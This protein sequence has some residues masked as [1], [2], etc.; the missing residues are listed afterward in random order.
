[1][2][3]CPLLLLQGKRTSV[4]TTPEAVIDENEPDPADQPAASGPPT[5]H[6]INF[7]PSSRPNVAV[8]GPK[9]KRP[10]VPK[11]P[12][13]AFDVPA[14][15]IFQQHEQARQPPRSPTPVSTD[16]FTDQVLAHLLASND[17]LF[18]TDLPGMQQPLMESQQHQ[19]SRRP[20]RP[21][22]HSDQTSMQP[23]LLQRRSF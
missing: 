22:L 11:L 12:L 14:T 23:D 4:S 16:S 21:R 1:M 6:P 20:R 2:T 13:T 8:Y 19:K 17:T 9:P 18:S 5:S 10:R 7:R 15:E 3:S